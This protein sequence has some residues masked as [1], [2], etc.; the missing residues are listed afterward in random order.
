MQKETS[1]AEFYYVAAIYS[2]QK[3]IL[4]KKKI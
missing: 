2:N 3:N 1:S 4:S